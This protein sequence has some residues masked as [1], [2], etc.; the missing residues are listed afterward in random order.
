MCLTVAFVSGVGAT[1]TC[2]ITNDSGGAQVSSI[3]PV[4]G[5][6]ELKVN[7][8]SPLTVYT[9]FDT[10][11]AGNGLELFLGYDKSDATTHGLHKD[12]N[13]GA[14]KKLVLSSYE[15]HLGSFFTASHVINPDASSRTNNDPLF[16]GRLYGV[17]IYGILPN[18][19]RTFSNLKVATLTFTNNLTDGE[20]TY[21]VLSDNGTGASYTDFWVAGGTYLA[22]PSYALKVTAVPE[23]VSLVLMGLGGVM[24]ARKR[25]S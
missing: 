17:Q 5:L 11:V 12:N 15:E 19:F 1:T 13:D 16:G 14:N 4:S 23:P 18:P 3:D 21:L 6:P 10:D 22:R 7:V 24:L 25:R 2:W 9:F 20:S 8:G